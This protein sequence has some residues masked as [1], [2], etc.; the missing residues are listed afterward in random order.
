MR[1]MV[2]TIAA[3]VCTL[4][5]T[6]VAMAQNSRS[7]EAP[8]SRIDNSDDKLPPSV[9]PPIS[10][11]PPTRGISGPRL[12]PGAVV[13]QTE[14][15]LQHRAIVS[16]RRAD[17]VMDAGNPLEGCHLLAQQRGVEIVDRHGLGRTEVKVK[18]TGETGW[19]DAFI[20]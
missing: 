1:R 5:A 19:T 17:G 10:T 9:P 8:R 14:E 7:S 4:A 6:D 2:V 20:R 12:E 13:C 15:D 18:P 11:L 3:L 16:Q